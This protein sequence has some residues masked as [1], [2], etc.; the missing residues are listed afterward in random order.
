M[1]LLNIRISQINFGIISWH[2][3]LYLLFIM[4]FCRQHWKNVLPRVQHKHWCSNVGPKFTQ[5]CKK[6]TDKNQ[7]IKFFFRS[8][9]NWVSLW[10]SNTTDI[11]FKE[12]CLSWL[13]QC[14]PNIHSRMFVTGCWN[15]IFPMLPLKL[16]K[17][18]FIWY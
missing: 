5:R 9:H 11:H 7:L 2:L 18:S 3:N 6:K 12:H 13:D 15:N 14:S 4:K 1:I 10:I 8:Y 17:N 16:L